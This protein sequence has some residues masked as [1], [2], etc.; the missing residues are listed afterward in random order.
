MEMEFFKKEF[1]SE[2]QLSFSNVELFYPFIDILEIFERIEK[3][4]TNLESE[5]EN[6]LET[7]LNIL[8][9]DFIIFHDILKAKISLKDICSRTSSS[10]ENEKFS[11]YSFSKKIIENKVFKSDEIIYSK[12]NFTDTKEIVY[13]LTLKMKIGNKRFLF[14]IG[15]FSNKPIS[16]RQY[17]I[18]K[19]IAKSLKLKLENIYEKES[20]KKNLYKDS[21]TKLYNRNFLKDVVPLELERANRYNYPI[22]VVMMDLDNFKIINDS[23]GHLFGDKILKTVG[24]IIRESIRKADIAIRY[25]GD[26]FI[27]FLPYTKKE[28]A[29]KIA[30]KIQNKIYN[31]NFD[32]NLDTK[33]GFSVSCGIFEVKKFEDI[34]SI[35][36]E[37]DKLLYISK[38]QGKGKIVIY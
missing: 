35:I 36:E 13:T 19:K 31:I 11:T 9:V 24:R 26:E 21:L 23:K 29:Y 20:L 6:L 4:P 32:L 22:S 38:N 27:I 18:F 5:L 30:R 10:K 14:V 1:S 2:T 17:F 25:G 37:A 16:F 8:D 7:L 34:D 3:N 12:I 15:N 33:I 28:N